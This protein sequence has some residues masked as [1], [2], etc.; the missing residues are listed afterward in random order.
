MVQNHAKRATDLEKRRGDFPR[1]YKIKT[2]LY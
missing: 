1:F 2:L